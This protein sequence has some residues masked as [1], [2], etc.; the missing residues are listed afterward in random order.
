[1][2]KKILVLLSGATLVALL[3]AGLVGVTAVSAQE[4][5]PEPEAP[6]GWRGGGRGRGGFGR[7]MFGPG[8]GGVEV[9]RATDGGAPRAQR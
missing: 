7:G 6:F 2:S 3:L 8:A 1:M 9:E 5:T 4:P